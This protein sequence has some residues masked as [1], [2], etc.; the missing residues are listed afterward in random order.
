MFDEDNGKTGRKLIEEVTDI[1][2]SRGLGE[3]DK[4]FSLAAGIYEK[5]EFFDG[6]PISPKYFAERIATRIESGELSA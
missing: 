1:L 6:E 5:N 3:Y 4:L 2:Q